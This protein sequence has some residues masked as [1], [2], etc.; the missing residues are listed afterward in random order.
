MSY[1]RL[2]DVQNWCPHLSAPGSWKHQ[3]TPSQWGHISFMI[4]TIMQAS[5][6]IG[7]ARMLKGSGASALS[8]NLRRPLDVHRMSSGRPLLPY[9]TVPYRT[10][11]LALRR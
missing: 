8:E 4:G 7:D 2:S 6:L 10:V 5:C 9:R 11:A 3:M 1:G